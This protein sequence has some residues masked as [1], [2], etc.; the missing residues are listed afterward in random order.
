MVTMIL[1]ARQQKKQID[2][3]N[4][5]LHYVGEDKGGMI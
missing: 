4:R 5:L 3:K 1:H 2:V